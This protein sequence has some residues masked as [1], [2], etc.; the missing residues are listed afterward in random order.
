MWAVHS[1]GNVLHGRI[2]WMYEAI[3]DTEE[4]ERARGKKS[5]AKFMVSKVIEPI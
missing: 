5:D 2:S 4:A 3:M 1:S